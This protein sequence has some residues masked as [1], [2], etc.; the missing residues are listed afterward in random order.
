MSENT[1]VKHFKNHTNTTPVKYFFTLKINN[2]IQQL[3][4]SNRTITEIAYDLNFEDPLYFS[5]VFKKITGFSPSCYKK[6]IIRK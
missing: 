6:E 2:A 4:N 3:T 1:F 5:R